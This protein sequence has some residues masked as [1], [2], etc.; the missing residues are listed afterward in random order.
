M[1]ESYTICSRVRLFFCA[2]LVPMF[3]DACTT[4]SKKQVSFRI[5]AGNIPACGVHRERKG[6]GK[7]TRHLSFPFARYWENNCITAAYLTFCFLHRIRFLS[8]FLPFSC[9]S[10]GIRTYIRVTQTKYRRFIIVDTRTCNFA[11]TVR[12]RKK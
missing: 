9:S 2:L 7:G 11:P 10:L 1:Y 5:Y 8:L 4:E 3:T 6:G 12:G